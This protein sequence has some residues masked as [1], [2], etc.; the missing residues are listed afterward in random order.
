MK[1]G[2]ILYVTQGKKELDNAPCPDL[3]GL[4][5]ELGVQSISLATSEDEISYVC[6]RMLA[7]GMHQVSCMH[8]RYFSEE[9]RLE[10]GKHPFRLAG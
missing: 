2:M 10:L 9:C 1:K 7:A 5:R 4:R 6:W 3:S 8:A